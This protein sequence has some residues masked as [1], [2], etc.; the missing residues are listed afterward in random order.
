MLFGMHVQWELSSVSVN[1]SVLLSNACSYSFDFHFYLFI[2]MLVSFVYY[3]YYFLCSFSF[4]L[5]KP[6][7]HLSSLSNIAFR[8][9][10]CGSLNWDRCLYLLA[11]IYLDL[12]R[13]MMVGTTPGVHRAGGSIAIVILQPKWQYL[14]LCIWATVS[15]HSFKTLLRVWTMDKTHKPCENWSWAKPTYH[16]MMKR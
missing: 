10:I 3:L 2:N 4:H 9:I 6:T 15:S 16:K 7:I 5:Q 13:R 12:S 8:K 11:D 1:Y 14:K